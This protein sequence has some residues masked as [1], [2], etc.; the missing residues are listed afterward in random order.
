MDLF[1]KNPSN[2]S[3][4]TCTITYLR[5]PVIIQSVEAFFISWHYEYVPKV[6]YMFL[7]LSNVILYS[8]PFKYL[9]GEQK[10]VLWHKGVHL[11]DI[12]H[13]DV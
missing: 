11:A 2:W 4:G 3:F 5:E 13:F 1:W 12:T 9:Y 10:S 7:Y 6:L 8:I